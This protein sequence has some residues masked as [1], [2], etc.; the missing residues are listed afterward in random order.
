M[1]HSVQ[2]FVSVNMKESFIYI[3]NNNISRTSIAIVHIHIGKRE[4][5]ANA[6]CTRIACISK[7]HI[8]ISFDTLLLRKGSTSRYSV[9]AHPGESPRT[10]HRGRLGK[11]K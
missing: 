2:N 7:E 9:F 11:R 10:H 1:E 8:C 6:C 4:K 3:V 5:F